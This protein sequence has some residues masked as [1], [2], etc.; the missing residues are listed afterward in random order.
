MLDT[1]KLIL[2]EQCETHKHLKKEETFWQN[3]LKTFYPLDRNEK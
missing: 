3:P 1:Q 2:F